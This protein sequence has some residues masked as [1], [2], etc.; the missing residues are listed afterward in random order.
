MKN[1]VLVTGGSGYIAVHIIKLLKAGYA[2]RTTLRNL[3]RAQEVRLTVQMGGA[4]TTNLTFVEADLTQDSHWAQAAA[5]AHFLIHVA[6][7]TPAT[8]PDDGQAM[9]DMAVDGTL[10]V[11]KAA[12]EAGIRRVVMTSASGAVIAGHGK[13]HPQIFTE[14][15]W[16][17]LQ[18]PIDAYQH[19]K[20]L[21]EQAA[22]AFA[23]K[24]DMQLT[25]VLPV[26][27]MGPVYGQDH[28]HSNQIIKNML[29]GKMP[30]LLNM[31][32]DYVDVRDVAELHLL[33]MTEDAAIGQRFIA[34]SGENLTYK[35]VARILKDHL[36]QD[37]AQV[38]EKVMPN[39]VVKALAPF[40]KDLKMPATFLGQN[41]ATSP[42]KAKSILNWQPRSAQESILATAE[43]FLKQK[44]AKD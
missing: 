38:S 34:T 44:I 10:R 27:V 40:V 2:V 21:S 15:D 7:P 17:N 31:G 18:G 9:V 29:T 23:E 24:Y 1:T 11:L 8:R 25:T 33:S 43:S 28:S 14:N 4:D 35:Q 19:S 42:D 12:H 3:A 6:S 32:F 39:F 26:A 36:D 5:N 20:T 41:T 13:S 37:A 30:F 16:T 22:W